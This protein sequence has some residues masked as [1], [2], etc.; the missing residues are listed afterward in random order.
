M[1]IKER[2]NIP[3]TALPTLDLQPGEP[4]NLCD[5]SELPRTNLGEE[6]LLTHRRVAIKQGGTLSVAGAYL[7]DLALLL[8]GCTSENEYRVPWS[9]QP[10]DVVKLSRA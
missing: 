9:D 3:S 7:W 5:S 2:N 4:S 1:S 8:D 10:H 6:D